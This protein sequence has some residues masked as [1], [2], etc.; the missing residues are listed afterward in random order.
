MTFK[1]FADI[2]DKIA[3]FLNEYLELGIIEKDVTFLEIW[4][5]EGNVTPNIIDHE[6]YSKNPGLNALFDIRM[7]LRGT[8]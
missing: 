4:Y 6:S 8:I 5:D 3:H 1:S 2:L 7:D